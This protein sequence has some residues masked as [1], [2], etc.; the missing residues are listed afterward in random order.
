MRGWVAC[1][2]G[3]MI[4]GHEMS[5]PTPSGFYILV[6]FALMAYAVVRFV[7]PG[8]VEELPPFTPEPCQLLPLAE[9]ERDVALDKLADMWERERI[10]DESYWETVDDVLARYERETAHSH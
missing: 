3:I 7:D 4:A 1:G 10:S 2:L 5:R 9:A 8:P 6:A